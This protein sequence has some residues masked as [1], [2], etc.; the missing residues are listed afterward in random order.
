MHDGRDAASD[1]PLA[2][3][4]QRM[5]HPGKQEAYV[6][7]LRKRALTVTRAIRS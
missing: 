4:G 5:Y 7:Y 3:L 6:T 1:A 2:P